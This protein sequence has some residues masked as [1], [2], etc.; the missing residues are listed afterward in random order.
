LKNNRPLFFLLITG[1]I[2]IWV[3]NA[4][5]FALLIVPRT[6]A[7]ADVRRQSDELLSPVFNRADSAL[8]CKPAIGAFKYTPN[9]ENPFRLLSEAFTPPARKKNT[10]ASMAR[11]TLTLKGVLLQERPLAILE[12]GAGKTFICGIGE[13]I[14]EFSIISIESN[15]V[16]L[17][18]SQGAVTLSVKE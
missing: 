10:P 8:R 11:I 15:K 6:T 3:A 7:T 4:Y 9:F 5:T 12:D 18:G 14:Q 1:A 2:G 17:R 16:T 13:N